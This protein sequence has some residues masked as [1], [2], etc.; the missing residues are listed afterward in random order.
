MS[1]SVTTVRFY[2]KKHLNE[3][4]CLRRP[5]IIY[6]NH[7]QKEYKWRLNDVYIRDIERLLSISARVMTCPRI[8]WFWLNYIS[9]I[10]EWFNNSCISE[11]CG[12]NEYSLIIWNWNPILSNTKFRISYRVK[13]QLWFNYLWFV[14]ILILVRA[15]YTNLTTLRLCDYVKGMKTITT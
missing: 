15:I 1:W 11:K 3:G 2:S 7:T 6:A 9:H 4:Q 10:L 8:S 12:I 5:G 13:N 14:T